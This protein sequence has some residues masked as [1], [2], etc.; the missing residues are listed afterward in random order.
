[1]ANILLV[2]TATEVCSVALATAG[3]VVALEE[4]T[5]GGRH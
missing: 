3:E 2:E 5:E 1:M 4:D